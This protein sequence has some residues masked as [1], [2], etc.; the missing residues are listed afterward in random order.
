M[1]MDD[2]DDLGGERKECKSASSINYYIQHVAYKKLI[3]LCSAVAA[4]AVNIIKRDN[5]QLSENWCGEGF[6]SSLI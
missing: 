1:K 3:N 2:D 6:S 4:V 5:E